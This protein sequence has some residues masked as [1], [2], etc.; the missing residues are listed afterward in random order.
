[1]SPRALHYDIF[2]DQALT[3]TILSFTES[4]AHVIHS[5]KTHPELY[6]THRRSYNNG[7]HGF[8][9]LLNSIILFLKKII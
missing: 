6:L 9:V 8:T 4:L 2:S 7:A 1:M 5:N 3:L